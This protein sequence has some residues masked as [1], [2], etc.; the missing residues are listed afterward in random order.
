ML[1]RLLLLAA[2]G[3]AALASTSC[4]SDLD[5]ELNGKCQ[6]GICQ[7]YA[8]W[9][10]DTCGE[11]QLLPASPENGF[12]HENLSSWGGTVL[13]DDDK[14]FHMFIGGFKFGCGLTSWFRNEEIL[15]AVSSTP[16]GPYKLRSGAA[17]TVSP[18]VATCPHAKKA[19]DGTYLIFHTS[20]GKPYEKNGT[21]YPPVGSS[22]DVGSCAGGITL[23]MP[24]GPPHI[25][26][27]PTGGP[28][29]CDG[30][31]TSILYSDSLDGPWKSIAVA[32][33]LAPSQFPYAV[34]NPTPCE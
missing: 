2:A 11:L 17:S 34:A 29:H 31:S 16:A 6:A 20:C 33:P 8:A 25:P 19:P 32:S 3:V 13:Q 18:L 12:K 22:R 10:G 1:L 9:G 26:Y 4:T 14:Q 28:P 21:L 15:H 30:Y 7:C 24:P 5:C 23:D 27:K